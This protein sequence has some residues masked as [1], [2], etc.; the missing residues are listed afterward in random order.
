V[1]SKVGHAAGYTLVE[2]LM[3]GAVMTIVAAIAIPQ[4]AL[5]LR[6]YAL[7]N[8]S[9]QV[10]STI[11]AARYAAVSKGTTLRIRFN[12]PATGQY[13]VVEVTSLSAIDQ[14]PARCSNT[15]Y[16]FPDPTA[17]MLPDNEGPVLLVPPGTEFGSVEDM[18]ISKEG[19][20]TPLTGCPA[21]A[22]TGGAVTL[23]L[24][25]GYETQATNIGQ[26]GRIEVEAV[27]DLDD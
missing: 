4:V 14:D 16:P 6:R 22:T 27:E 21:C 20:V 9:Q 1:R 8:A 15:A 26:N 12:C 24:E 18:E 19:R 23:A 3:V 5:A 11:R 10:A 25:N 17:G 2:V 7:N 13:R